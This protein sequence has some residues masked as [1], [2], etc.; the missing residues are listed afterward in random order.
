MGITDP[1]KYC[2]CCGENVP[3]NTLTKDDQVIY[4]CIYCG[5]TVGTQS[6]QKIGLLKRVYIAEDSAFVRNLLKDAL[7]KEGIVEQLKGFGNGAELFS[8]LC[9]IWDGGEHVDLLLLD[10]QMPVLDGLKAAT[11]IRSEEA[12]RKLSRTPIIFFSAARCTESLKTVITKWAPAAYI[13]KGS[14]FDP[15]RVSER[16][17]DLIRYIV[18]NSKIGKKSERES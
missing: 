4:N 16:V 13:N 18:N 7:Q 14:D 11:M 10:I 3:Y 1:Q 2:L 12:K 8:A 17:D 9:G 15:M 5:F 6:T